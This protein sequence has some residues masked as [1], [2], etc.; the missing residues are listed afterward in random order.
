[1]K[2][3]EETDTE[4]PLCEPMQQSDVKLHALFLCGVKKVLCSLAHSLTH[5]TVLNTKLLFFLF[6]FKFYIW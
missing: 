6:A 2:K 5:I 1:M 3:S 4:C